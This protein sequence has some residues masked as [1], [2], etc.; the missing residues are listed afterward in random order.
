MAGLRRVGCRVVGARLDDREPCARGV[1][2]ERVEDELDRLDEELERLLAA[3]ARR[4]RSAGGGI[5]L[6]VRA[7]YTSTRIGRITGRRPV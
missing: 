5:R 2:L 4:V 6:L 7:I 3:G 1:E